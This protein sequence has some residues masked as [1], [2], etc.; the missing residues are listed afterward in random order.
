MDL[1]KHFPKSRLNFSKGFVSYSP[2][3][4]EHQIS[5]MDLLTTAPEEISHRTGVPVKEC[6]YFIQVLKEESFQVRDSSGDDLGC[7]T[8]GD[9]EIDAMLGGGIHTG[10]ITEIFGESATGKSQFCMQLTK[11][12]ALSVEEGGLGAK[13]VYISTEGSLETRRLM[14][15]NGALDSVF[16]INCMDLETQLHV[17]EVQLPL[18]L[19]QECVKLVVID[20]ISH[21]LRVELG[22]GGYK[23]FIKTKHRLTELCTR[24][25]DL[26]AEFGIA[27]VATNQISDLPEREI[28]QSD[29]KKIAVDYQQGWLSGW[30]AAMIESDEIKG[31]IPTLG[32]AWSNNVL[33]RILL[34]KHY[35]RGSEEHWSVHRSLK[36]VFSPLNPDNSELAFEIHK[37]GLRAMS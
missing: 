32:L 20:S 26:C 35:E 21:H 30:D 22:N 11:S 18:L 31:V 13:S 28:L 14:E 23:S 34:K 37:N 1:Y 36:L 17:M 8:T 4:T 19:A 33:V 2:L 7:F 5:V 25:L 12:V 27:L 6:A 16:C 15:I 24:L 3:L 9:D 29:Y 10:Q